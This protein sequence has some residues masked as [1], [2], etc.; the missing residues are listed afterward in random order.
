MLH[1]AFFIVPL[2]SLP[3]DPKPSTVYEYCTNFLWRKIVLGGTRTNKVLGTSDSSYGWRVYIATKYFYMRVINWDNCAMNV[4][5][6]KW[7]NNSI[8]V[9]QIHSQLIISNEFAQ[10]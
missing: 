2:C 8:N 1:D 10:L 4:R 5:A 3:V 9:M 6:D 7:K